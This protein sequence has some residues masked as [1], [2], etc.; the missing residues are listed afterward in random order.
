MI[1]VMISSCLITI[2][3]YN[4]FN[5]YCAV[6]WIVQNN[7]N[8]MKS[9]QAKIKPARPDSLTLNNLSKQIVPSY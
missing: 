6:N 5:K 1:T 8:I 9:S 7:H 4:F 3:C 2:L